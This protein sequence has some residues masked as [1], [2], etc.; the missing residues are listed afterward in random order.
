MPRL[1]TKI[2]VVGSGIAG[3]LCAKYLAQHTDDI[4]IVERGA[5][6]SHEWRLRNHS[7]EIHISTARHSHSVVGPFADKK[8]QYVYALGGS[9]NHWIGN[10]PRFLPNDFRMNSTYGVMLDWLVP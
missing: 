10:T 4:L 8:I 5:G 3:C 1:K 2:C 7:Q 6:V 9:T